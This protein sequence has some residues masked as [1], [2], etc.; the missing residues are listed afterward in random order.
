MTRAMSRKLSVSRGP[1]LTRRMT[2]TA[3]LSN[4]KE[5]ATPR[6]SGDSL[7]H[8]PDQGAGECLHM[9]RQQT[10]VPV[11]YKT[12]PGNGTFLTTA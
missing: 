1:E 5:A 12:H 10:G 3:G 7:P 9:S 11:P 2:Y 6:P 8:L 4:I